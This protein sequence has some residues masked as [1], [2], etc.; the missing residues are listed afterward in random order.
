MEMME[1]RRAL[2]STPQR[3][4]W[5]FLDEHTFTGQSQ[6]RYTITPQPSW[7]KY[8]FIFIKTDLMFTP[9]QEEAKGNWLWFRINDGVN[10]PSSWDG[11]G[12]SGARGEEYSAILIRN[13]TDEKWYFHTLRG[14]RGVSITS[15]A[16]LADIT[17][18]FGAYYNSPY[19]LLTGTIEVYGGSFREGSAS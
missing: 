18:E 14:N 5:D 13:T 4:Y 7:A 12:S 1:L 6:E 9:P 2:T 11:T 8:D 3:L 15:S 16:T 10:A 19:D 17:I